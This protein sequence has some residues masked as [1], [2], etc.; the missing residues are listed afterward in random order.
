M[1]AAQKIRDRTAR[2]ATR[3]LRGEV[4]SYFA[5]VEHAVSKVLVRAADLPDYE[6]SKPPLPHLF[7]QKRD[8]LR[9]LM[10]EAGP[11]KSR[12]DEVTPLLDK[13][14]TFDE[15][16]NFMAHGIAEVAQSG[17]P[18]YVF[19]MLCADGSPISPLRRTHRESQSETAKLANI[20]GELASTLEAIAEALTS[21]RRTS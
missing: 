14:A 16:R 18:V 2:R 1:Q 21:R 17:E 9:T 7:S 20:A 10:G 5:E 11:L 12:A 15:L 6:A 13:L 4:I 19:R 8:R 3:R